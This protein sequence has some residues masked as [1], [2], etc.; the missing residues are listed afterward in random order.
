MLPQIQ[1][2][3]LLTPEVSAGERFTIHVKVIGGE[4]PFEY[5]FS[6]ESLTEPKIIFIAKEE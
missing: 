6:N 2:V 4:G 1:E 3:S 5:P